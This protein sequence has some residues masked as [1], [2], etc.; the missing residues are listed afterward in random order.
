MSP[1]PRPTA[2]QLRANG[3]RYLRASMRAAWD[4]CTRPETAAWLFAQATG[5]YQ[6]ALEAQHKAPD[7]T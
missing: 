6:E 3:D 2:A 7:D 4:G 1:K 5:C